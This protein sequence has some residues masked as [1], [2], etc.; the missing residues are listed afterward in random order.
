MT[1]QSF[2][3]V[4]Q[5]K[6]GS[7]GFGKI[8]QIQHKHTKLNYA[9]K[10]TKTN[11]NEINYMIKL[12]NHRNIIKFHECYNFDT[13]IAIVMEECTGMNL[14]DALSIVENVDD[15][16]FLRD[17]YILQCIDAIEY[18]HVNSII[19]RDIKHTNSTRLK[20]KVYC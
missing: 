10:L 2:P 4:F 1:S 5:K 14:L 17:Y 8:Y 15:K 16:N 6:L 7:G 3:Y 11:M 12:K 9:C 19:H 20:T 13:K 18:C